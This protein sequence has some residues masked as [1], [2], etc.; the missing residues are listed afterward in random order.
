MNA[1]ESKML[2]GVS[3][4]EGVIGAQI[5]K[6]GDECVKK[7]PEI[8][9][10]VTIEREREK[11]KRK[12]KTAKNDRQ[13][14]GDKQQT[15]VEGMDGDRQGSKGEEK[16][17]RHKQTKNKAML[18]LSLSLS[19]SLSLSLS[20]CSM[21]GEKQANLQPIRNTNRKAAEEHQASEKP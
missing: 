10:G 6:P 12:R 11:R 13:R 7:Q 4:C 3:C 8:L 18:S 1:A 5:A 19:H 9:K 16:G 17:G 2:R 14:G 15:K 21:Q 20:L